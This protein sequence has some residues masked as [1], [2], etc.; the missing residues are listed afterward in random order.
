MYPF[1]YQRATDLAEALA[2]L[3]ADPQARL[4]AGG[5]TLLPSMKHRLAAP[6]RLIDIARLPALRGIG[7]DGNALVVGAAPVSGAGARHAGVHRAR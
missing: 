2:A 6:S 7:L 3:R 1:S 5:M 4:L